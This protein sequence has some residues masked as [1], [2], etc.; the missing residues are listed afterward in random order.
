MSHGREHGCREG[1]GIGNDNQSA[2]VVKWSQYFMIFLGNPVV[3]G[4]Q[5]VS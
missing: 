2:T 3:S 1:E 4:K 5:Q